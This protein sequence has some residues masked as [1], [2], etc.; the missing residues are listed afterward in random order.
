MTT[1]RAAAATAAG[2]LT[3][4]VL[5]ALGLVTGAAASAAP[6]CG[7]M[8]AIVVPGTTETNPN[9][10]P[11]VVPGM[12]GSWSRGLEQA[13]PGARVQ[14]VPYTAQVGGPIAG[15]VTHQGTDLSQSYGMGVARTTTALQQAA[16]RCPGTPLD[17]VGFSQGAGVAAKVCSGVGTGAIQLSG[18]AGRIKSCELFGNPYRSAGGLI[19]GSG[20]QGDGLNYGTLG[21]RIN[22]WCASGDPICGF[23]R[24][25]VAAGLGGGEGGTGAA[26]ASAPWA[27]SNALPQVLAD[28][29]GSFAGWNQ[30]PTGY[31]VAS[32]AFG[33]KSA[34]QASVDRVTGK[35]AALGSGAGTQN[36]SYVPAGGFDMS[37]LSTV[38]SIL[39][40]F[41]SMAGG[42]ESGLSGL[43]SSFTTSSPGTSTPSAL[44]GG[45]SLLPGSTSTQNVSPSALPGGMSVLPGAVTDQS[46][47]GIAMPAPAATGTGLEHVNGQGIG[48]GIGSLLG[49]F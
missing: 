48:Q 12:L 4:A 33:G 43:P 18:G 29:A 14:S 15:I 19:S 31:T 3:I 22:N 1:M 37:S 5:P 42:D 28:A 6:G 39:G 49:L 44:P 2:T 10:N 26:S 24:G 7:T 23:R 21:N 40:G 30:H 20:I 11:D 27:G 17:L 36:G 35:T 8:Q 46:T 16:T 45:M 34:V 9:A 41:S 47:T 32:P 38:S 13:D 25:D